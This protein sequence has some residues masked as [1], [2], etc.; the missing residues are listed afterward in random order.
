MMFP[1]RGGMYASRKAATLQGAA[2]NKRKELHQQV[3]TILP[4]LEAGQLPNPTD[5]KV[6][7]EAAEFYCYMEC[8]VHRTLS[9]IPT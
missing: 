5:A 4:K 1:L 9:N 8:D 6:L 7:E 3:L 2:M